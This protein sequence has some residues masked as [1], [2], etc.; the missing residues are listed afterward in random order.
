MKS[1][2]TIGL[3]LI[4]LLL[5]SCAEKP[6][7]L[8]EDKIIDLIQSSIS[9]NPN[10]IKKQFTF[11]TGGMDKMIIPK[12]DVSDIHYLGKGNRN[13]VEVWTIKY[14]A[15]G[16]VIASGK[17]GGMYEFEYED[18]VQFS[19]NGDSWSLKF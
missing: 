12:V 13:G 2:K 5:N 8:G 1:I 10:H 15:K 7:G 19:K 14:K 9:G 18:K 11:Q 3:L 4:L 6:D 17:Q 16:S